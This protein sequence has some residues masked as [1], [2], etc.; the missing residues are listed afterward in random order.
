MPNLDAQRDARDSSE[1]AP[2][3]VAMTLWEIL[4]VEAGLRKLEASGEVNRGDLQR[5]IKRIENA[6]QIYTQARRTVPA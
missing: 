1:V 5:L 2:A 3:P 4:A 6:N